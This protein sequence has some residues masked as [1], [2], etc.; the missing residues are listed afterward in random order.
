MLDDYFS[1]AQSIDLLTADNPAFQD[2]YQLRFS[3][4][5]TGRTHETQRGSRSLRL[6]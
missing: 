6:V 1:R 4:M 3:R 2:F 5:V